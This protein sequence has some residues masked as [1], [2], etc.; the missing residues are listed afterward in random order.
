LLTVDGT[1]GLAA[2]EDCKYRFYIGM[3]RSCRRISGDSHLPPHLYKSGGYVKRLPD[4]FRIAFSATSMAS[5]SAGALFSPSDMRMVDHAILRDTPI[6]L[7]TC[8]I[9]S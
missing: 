9:Q 4:G 6:T 1:L 5:T 3:G 2:E 7:R 8:E